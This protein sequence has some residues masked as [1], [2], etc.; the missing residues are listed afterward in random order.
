MQ[1]CRWTPHRGR[2]GK[3]LGREGM[4]GSASAADEAAA[5]FACVSASRSCARRRISEPVNFFLVLA[6]WS[7]SA[8]TKAAVAAAESA[9]FSASKED[10]ISRCSELPDLCL[11]GCMGECDPLLVGPRSGVK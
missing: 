4:F 11:E 5:V 2:Q 10:F 9:A 1:I 8:A 7:A 3:K 6:G